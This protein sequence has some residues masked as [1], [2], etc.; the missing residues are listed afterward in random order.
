MIRGI[1]V[2]A[3]SIERIEK[4]EFSD[5]TI[6]RLF[7]PQEVE[8]AQNLGPLKAQFLASRFA[9][10]EAFVKALGLGF[11]AISP[12]NICVTVDKEGRPT[13]AL[14][15]SD[16]KRLNLQQVEIHL[17]LT[18]ENPLAIAFVVLEERDGSL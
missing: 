12:S 1:G 7:H 8:E 14:S 15:F 3:V 2:D 9:A 18:H 13:I 16:K 6:K 11:K 5:H 17:S 4:K 10:K